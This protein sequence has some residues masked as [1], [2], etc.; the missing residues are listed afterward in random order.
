MPVKKIVKTVRNKISIVDYSPSSY[1]EKITY[2]LDDC[3]PYKETT[4][5]SWINIDN[6][7]PAKF[8]G[9]LGLGFDLHPIILE[10]IEDVDQRPKIEIFDDY[11]II[12][13]KMLSLDKSERHVITEQVSIIVSK[14]FVITFQQ[15][16]EGDSFEFVR[17]LLKKEKSRLRHNGTDYL[18]YE[19]INSVIDGYYKIL[20]KFGDRLERVEEKIIADPTVKMLKTIHSLKR[21]LINMRKFVWPLREVIGVLERDDSTLI[22]KG[23]RIYLR[24]LY[25]RLV[26]VMD[27]AETNRDMLS[28][29]L[30]IYLSGVSNKTNTVMKT[31]TIF[32]TIFLPLSFVASVWSMNFDN[33]PGTGSYWGLPLVVLIMIIITTMMLRHF[34]NK[35]WL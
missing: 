20:D 21:E 34:K 35:E 28:S 17:K 5:V 27:I 3:I 2:K 1:E 29:L 6:V 23:T 30:D 31:L 16:I 24:D 26:H 7:P 9:K 8:L 33:I 32:S 13:L 15:G 10:D 12:I 11:I 4:T 19:L 14:K 18:A 22:K 25:D